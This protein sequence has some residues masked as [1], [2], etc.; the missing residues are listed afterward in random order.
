MLPQSLKLGVGV[1]KWEAGQDQDLF[2]HVLGLSGVE[3]AA[4]RDKWGQ[5]GQK[6]AQVFPCRT[7]INFVL[8]LRMDCGHCCF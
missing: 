6:L 8:C 7:L 1:S 5:R 3:R 4:E 2:Q